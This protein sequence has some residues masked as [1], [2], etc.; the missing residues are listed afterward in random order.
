MCESYY[1]DEKS[2]IEAYSR[3]Y[4]VSV[5]N[6]VKDLKI[7]VKLQS[8]DTE[9]ADDVI[10]GIVFAPDG[11][12]MDMDV[13]LNDKEM[14]IALAE[15]MA[16]DCT[17]FGTVL[18]EDGKTC[19]MSLGTDTSDKDNTKYY[20]YYE[21]PYAAP[22]EYLVKIYHHPEET[23]ILEPVVRDKTETDTEIIVVD[24]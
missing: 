7:K 22:G 11:T 8:V 18:C 5:P 3:Q 19:E 24:G 17:I 2:K 10:Q 1:M 15:G 6:R 16:G 20:L 4:N 13:N 21:V 14:N 9:Y 12:Q 23:S